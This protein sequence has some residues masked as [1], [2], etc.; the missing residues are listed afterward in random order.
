MGIELKSYDVAEHLDS[1]EE[2]RLY[3]EAEF[4]AAK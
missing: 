1:E 3:L 2:I 4:E